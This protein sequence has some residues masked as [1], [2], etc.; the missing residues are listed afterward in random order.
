[1]VSFT[2]VPASFGGITTV[3]VVPGAGTPVIT[4]VDVLKKFLSK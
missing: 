3:V 4:V 2:S 1:M